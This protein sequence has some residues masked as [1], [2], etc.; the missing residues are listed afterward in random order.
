MHLSAPQRSRR[1]WQAVYSVARSRL[2]LR[3]R[4]P[5]LMKIAGV[6]LSIVALTLIARTFLHS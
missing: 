2:S 5:Q 1:S 6:A 4:S 3:L